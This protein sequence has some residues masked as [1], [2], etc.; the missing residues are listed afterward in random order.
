MTSAQF[1][2]T[3]A[4]TNAERETGLTSTSTAV[5]LLRSPDTIPAME[6][7]IANSVICALFF[8]NCRYAST[9][10]GSGI[11]MLTPVWLPASESTS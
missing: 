10:V 11:S 8:E 2:T 4:V 7:M 1:E 5:P 9:V 3:L 6:M